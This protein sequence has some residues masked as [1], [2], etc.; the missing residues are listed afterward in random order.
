MAGVVDSE[1]KL[2]HP[3]GFSNLNN[4]DGSSDTSCNKRSFLCEI[5]KTLDIGKAIGY[6]LEGCYDR[7]KEL[8]EGNGNKLVLG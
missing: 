7:V 3:P 4:L 8:V 5:Q 1:D 6:N 2:T